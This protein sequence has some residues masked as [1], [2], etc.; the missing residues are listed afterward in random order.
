MSLQFF[1]KSHCHC[2]ET[3]REIR[4]STKLWACCCNGAS[5]GFSLSNSLSL[6][7]ICMSSLVYS[8]LLLY[9]LYLLLLGFLI[10]AGVGFWNFF[11][12]TV[13]ALFQINTHTHTHPWIH[14]PNPNQQNDT[15]TTTT[16]IQL[17]H[18]FFFYPLLQHY[19][20]Y[21]NSNC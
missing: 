14:P 8:L 13:V 12:S 5:H 21:N 10:L 9:F 16:T 11:C 20:C 3:K 18:F 19:Y 4:H 1:I 15:T 17:K 6:E 7:C 2:Q